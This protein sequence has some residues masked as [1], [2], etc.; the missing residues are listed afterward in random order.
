MQKYSKI[1]DFEI[2][3][4]GIM[5]DSSVARLKLECQMKGKTSGIRFARGFSLD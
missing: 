4:T 2:A 1:T 5:W 3:E